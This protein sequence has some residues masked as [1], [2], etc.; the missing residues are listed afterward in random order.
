MATKKKQKAPAKRISAA[1]TRFLRKQNP[2]HMKG[3]THVRVKK[4]KGGGVTITP[5]HS[6]RGA[7]CNRRRGS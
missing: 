1:L 2:G 7:R 6:N 3:V 4:L 5:V